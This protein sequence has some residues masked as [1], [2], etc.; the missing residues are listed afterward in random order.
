MDAN[1]NLV[2]DQVSKD[3][4]IEP[5]IL[6]SALEEAILVAAKRSFGAERNLVA[7]Y[8]ED[9]GAVDLTQ[10]ITVVETV[11]DTFNEISTV[12]CEERGIEVKYHEDLSDP[13][14]C[15]FATYASNPLSTPAAL[16]PVGHPGRTV[17]GSVVRSA[18]HRAPCT[19]TTALPAMC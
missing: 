10:T 17:R 2:L 14:A 18:V 1:L 3:K 7:A 8:N 6:Q 16:L 11:E 5:G 15:H 19:Y 4:G 12:E 9:K 13:L